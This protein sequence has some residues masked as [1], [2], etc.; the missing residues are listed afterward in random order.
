[1]LSLQSGFL[2]PAVSPRRRVP[3]PS[4]ASLPSTSLFQNWAKVWTWGDP[5]LF[6]GPLAALL[7][8]APPQFRGLTLCIGSRSLFCT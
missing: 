4:Q 7:R 6:L 3:K 8:A 5:H 2:K 1:M